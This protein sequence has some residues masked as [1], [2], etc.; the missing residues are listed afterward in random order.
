M[1][2]TSVFI[3]NRIPLLTK[4]ESNRFLADQSTVKLQTASHTILAAEDVRSARTFF[5]PP[6]LPFSIAV[7]IASTPHKLKRSGNNLHRS[8]LLEKQKCFPKKKKREEKTLE[9]NISIPPKG[10]K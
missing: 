6:A 8:N 2:S 7:K 3:T 1:S 4:R 9:K 5:V 10:G